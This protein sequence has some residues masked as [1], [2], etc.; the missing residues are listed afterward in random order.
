MVKCQNTNQNLLFHFFN[1]RSI[2]NTARE[3]LT[4]DIQ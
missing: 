3:R 4:S 1:L 2:K